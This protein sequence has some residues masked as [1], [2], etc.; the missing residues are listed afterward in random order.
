MFAGLENKL[1]FE[2]VC[3]PPINKS[4]KEEN[5]KTCQNTETDNGVKQVYTL[6]VCLQNG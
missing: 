4:T 6:A 2:G 3:D 1:K 5:S